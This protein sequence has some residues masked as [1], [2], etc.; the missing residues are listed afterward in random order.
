MERYP[1]P[2]GHQFEGRMVADDERYL[3]S[4][5]A[6]LLP[7]HQIIK[8]MRGFCDQDSYSLYMIRVVDR[9]AQVERIAELCELFLHSL[10]RHRERVQVQFYPHEI[11]VVGHIGVLL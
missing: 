8:T 9:P 7:Q 6:L 2:V 10:P 1:E 3:A 5:L 11:E 4:D